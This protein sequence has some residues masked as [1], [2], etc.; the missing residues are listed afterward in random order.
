VFAFV[1]LALLGATIL[2]TWHFST[3]QRLAR[4]LRNTPRR[5]IAEAGEGRPCRVLGVVA[6]GRTIDAPLSGR[7]C[8][9]FRVHVAERVGE[10]IRFFAEDE[11]GIPFVVVDDTGP[12][13]VDPRPAVSTLEEDFSATSGPGAPADGRIGAFLARIGRTD[14]IVGGYRHLQYWEAIVEPGETVSVLGIGA[15]ELDPGAVER[16]AGYRVEA[17]TRLRIGGSARVPVVLSDRPEAR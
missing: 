2:A 3:D 4:L 8:V 1:L 11:G 5:P 16:V 12:A 7:P 15:R 6:P 9:Y 13:L 14:E 10:G 17:P